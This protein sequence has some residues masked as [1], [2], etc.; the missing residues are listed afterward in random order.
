MAS[1]AKELLPPGFHPT[2][3]PDWLSLGHILPSKPIVRTLH[4]SDW[5]ARVRGL[6]LPPDRCFHLDWE[7][8]GR[9]LGEG[10]SAL[11]PE[12]WVGVLQA[13]REGQGT[14]RKCQDPGP[15]LR[16][17]HSQQSPM[18]DAH[19]ACCRA[20]E[21]H[22]NRSTPGC[23][24]SSNLHALSKLQPPPLAAGSVTLTSR[25]YASI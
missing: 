19:A 6:C 5:P 7:S 10:V 14:S 17:A 18:L 20:G 25:E 12:K 9:L 4:S 21:L 1:G 16:P 3:D 23:V 2:Q 8:Q 22:H 15:R 13:R 11:R 24:A